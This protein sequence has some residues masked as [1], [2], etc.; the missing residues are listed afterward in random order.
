[1]DS[2]DLSKLY[3]A[4]YG[5]ALKIYA[6]SSGEVLL[7]GTDIMK[8]KSF[9]KIDMPNKSLVT[10]PIFRIGVLCDRDQ[11][12]AIMQNKKDLVVSLSMVCKDMRQTDNDGKE[13]GI[14]QEHTLFDLKF[15][16][17]IETPEEPGISNAENQIVQDNEDG[18]KV[19]PNDPRVAQQYK[20]LMLN[21]SCTMHRNRFK[22]AINFVHTMDGTD[23]QAKPFDALC[24]GI[25][26]LITE[27]KAV[28]I[29][30]PDNTT[31][32]LQ[33]IVPPWNLREFCTFM[34]TVYG[35][36]STGMLVFQDLKYLYVIPKYSDEYAV[37]E[38]EYDT[39]HIFILSPETTS[40]SNVI[41]YYKD[42]D[43]MKYVVTTGGRGAFTPVDTSEALKELQGNKFR[44]LDT[45]S[46][47]PSTTYDAEQWAG[48]DPMPEYDAGIEGSNK[49]A[50]DK[51]RYFHN[52][53]SNPYI[54]DEHVLDL[55]FGQK[56][57]SVQVKDVDFS[58]LTFNRKYK[59]TFLQDVNI[60]AQYGGDY[61]LYD[62]KHFGQAENKEPILSTSVLTL[63]KKP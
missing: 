20:L 11:H 9:V 57:I 47:E 13:D 55:Q 45:D 4:Q 8:L 14:V 40:G 51:V 56:I 16:A 60:D 1:M 28:I 44:V 21:L 53:L 24:Y 26:S 36:Y 61:R 63:L 50:G 30:K 43:K 7:E 49:D 42:D 23:P 33:V 58:I 17:L 6:G 59:L 32:E 19:G 48:A 5:Y 62:V 15:Q 29:Q 35:V 27:E 34:Q 10:F 31:P 38:D 41:G 18:S 22:T 54:L 37:A 12:I 39:V 46:Y 3:R 2:P 25:S 52:E